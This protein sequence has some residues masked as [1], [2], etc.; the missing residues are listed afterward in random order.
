MLDLDNT[1]WGGVIGDDGLEGIVLGHGNPSGEAYLGVQR[2]ALELRARGVVL[3]VCSR[4]DDD[5]ARLPFRHHPDMVLKEEDIAV[6][7]ANWQDKAANLEAIAEHLDLGLDALVFVDDNPVERDLVRRVLPQ[8]AVPELPDDSSLFPRAVLAA[9]YFEATAFTGDDRHRADQYRANAERAALRRTS[10]DLDGFLES[11][12]MRIT[13]QPFDPLGRSRITQLINRT[14]QFNLTGRRYTEAEV[15]ALEHD[16]GVFTLQVRLVDRF[17]DNG[18]VGV[19]ICRRD[20]EAWI[21]DTWLMSCRVLNRRLE[22]AVLDE[23]VRQA[24]RAG[25]ATLIGRYVPTGRNGLVRDH[26]PGLGFAPDGETDGVTSWRYGVARHVRRHPP[27]TLVPGHPS[28][29]ATII[30]G[31]Y[32]AEPET[33]APPYPDSGF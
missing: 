4:N 22:E 11:L 29:R 24:A 20:G 33:T 30:Q 28:D 5:A 7:Q 14:N 13:F 21:V 6:F 15:E 9:G 27:I 19:V 23:L 1:L 16:P 25:V 2:M 17:G 26:Y 12:E 3:A 18:M 32:S 8:V 10:R 31:A